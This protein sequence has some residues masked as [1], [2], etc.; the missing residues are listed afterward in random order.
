MLPS[1]LSYFLSPAMGIKKE[2]KKDEHSGLNGN[3]AWGLQR[4]EK[5]ASRFV[6]QPFRLKYKTASTLLG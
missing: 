5:C 2:I 6:F 1:A 3:Q 4:A